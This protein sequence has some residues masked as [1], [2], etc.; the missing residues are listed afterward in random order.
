MDTDG[1]REHPEFPASL[2]QLRSVEMCPYCF[3]A[4]RGADAC[5]ECGLDLTD[6]R[7]ADVFTLS[8]RAATALSLRGQLL[9]GVIGA[10]RE[11][12]DTRIEAEAEAPAT[13]STA[14]AD[15]MPPLPEISAE[16]VHPVEPIS[17]TPP[18]PP[19][20][21][22]PRVSTPDTAPSAQPARP[23]IAGAWMTSAPDAAGGWGARAT[24][25]QAAAAEPAKP[26]R[27]GVQLALLV[28]GIAFL[29]VAAIVFLTVAFVLFDLMVKALITAAVT[30]TVI[31][32]A[33]W[34]GRRKMTATAEGVAVLGVVL[35]GLDF[36]AVR[37][38][39]MFGLDV[40]DPASYWG[41][42]L[43]GLT[44]I[45]LG[46]TRLSG[47]ATPKF[48]AAL[49]GLPAVLL[50]VASLTQL[51]PGGDALWGLS[52]AAAAAASAATPL[53][54]RTST[55]EGGRAPD[56]LPVGLNLGIGLLAGAIAPL[57]AGLG[58]TDTVDTT[59]A[60]VSMLLALGGSL[61]IVFWHDRARPG[62]PFGAFAHIAAAL[63]AWH[64]LALGHKVGQLATAAGSDAVDP[65]QGLP[66]ALPVLVAL[67]LVWQRLP[68][69]AP[70]RR[71]I[72]QV[73]TIAAAVAAVV[74]VVM[75]LWH[76]TVVGVD[77]A[78]NG[79]DV[80][81]RSALAIPAFLTAAL[82]A[83]PLVGMRFDSDVLPRRALTRI[84]AGV[85]GVL[86]TVGAAGLPRPAVY[87]T[88]CVAL[89]L[90]VALVVVAR[91]DAGADARG[92]TDAQATAD[93][94]VAADARAQA[95]QTL[96]ARGHAPFGV[97]G[98]ALT[99]ASATLLE[100]F[101]GI[102][103]ALATV[104]L[105]ALALA[106][107]ATRFIRVAAPGAWLSAAGISVAAIA[108]GNAFLSP[109]EW[110]PAAPLDSLARLF[111]LTLVPALLL[112]LGALG[113]ASR[114]S[115][116]EPPLLAGAGLA[117]ALPLGV[118]PMFA[119]VRDTDGYA[120]TYFA[121]AAL[122]LALIVAAAISAARHES[123]GRGP[124]I[125]LVGIVPVTVTA[126]W[127]LLHTI[128]G[129][130]AVW[131]AP[132]AAMTVAVLALIV[133]VATRARI[134]TLATEATNL[135]VVGAALLWLL[136]RSWTGPFEVADWLAFAVVLAAPLLSVVAA[137]RHPRWRAAAPW[138][139]A[140]ALAL[141]GP[142]FVVST[143]TGE[144][145]AIL[146]ATPVI[147]VAVTAFI[148]ALARSGRYSG[149]AAQLAISA[150]AALFV[151]NGALVTDWQR[152]PA[153]PTLLAINFVV[154]AVAWR[155]APPVGRWVRAAAGTVAAHGVLVGF[156]AVAAWLLDTWNAQGGLSGWTVSL[157][158]GAATL[159]GVTLALGAT[160]RILAHS[161][162]L[163][164]ALRRAIAI[165]ALAA[166][167]VTV[168]VMPVALAVTAARPLDVVAVVAAVPAAI[169]AV[170][171]WQRD[172]VGSLIGGVA[173]A[174]ASAVAI[175]V[176]GL[177][178]LGQL[179]AYRADVATQVVVTAI[180]AIGAAL[181]L[182]RAVSTQLRWPA[183]WLLLTA[184][185]L[186]FDPLGTWWAI[187]AASVP[188]LGVAVTTAV[189]HWRDETAKPRAELFVLALPLLTATMTSELDHGKLALLVTGLAA[190]IVAFGATLPRAFSVG[191]ALARA[192]STGL[193][194]IALLWLWGGGPS[195]EPYFIGAI[196]LVSVAGVWLVLR[197]FPQASVV[198]ERCVYAAGAPVLFTAIVTGVLAE[199]PVATA[200][201]VVV[202]ALVALGVSAVAERVRAGDVVAAS[203][204][205]LSFT[206]MGASIAFAE[207]V[208]AAD[209]WM[210][211]PVLLC[212]VAAGAIAMRGRPGLRSF[213]AVGAPLG[214]ALFVLVNSEGVTPSW[215]RIG[216]ATVLIVATILVGA[217]GRLQAPLV[218]GI[219]AAIA[220][221]FVAGRTV[222]PDIAIPWWAWLAAAGIVLVFVA[223][224]YERRMQQARRIAVGLR[225]M[226]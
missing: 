133:R 18:A 181:T 35:L 177:T 10:Q 17:S 81:G 51:R 78:A 53:L 42:A 194:I 213:A 158:L 24:P 161:A 83:L 45:L 62:G 75:F 192:G 41:T 136:L 190:M 32:T 52:F 142:G 67:A 3:T 134:D 28:T 188:A 59:I 46:W 70:S 27:S 122:T 216:L 217:L 113:A 49:T 105:T 139:P 92:G 164:E 130:A 137:N 106:L 150:V 80:A 47:L 189:R 96:P 21:P 65:G 11:A 168:A 61:A 207:G 180:A 221:V 173:L 201:G 206:A 69:R 68:L 169:A 114:L 211:L 125:A 63:V 143:V 14:A 205:T 223:A 175:G 135:L 89:A 123:P 79:D 40:A 209:V 71:S 29:A 44:A 34:L 36:W 115:K 222:L 184:L 38:L 97:A 153:A 159:V 199:T 6:A 218:L 76:I 9:Q 147:A 118:F 77:L 151:T 202:S 104:A 186:Y 98:T 214:L 31:A 185:P 138:I 219:I 196:G 155:A 132:I 82:A 15:E 178:L 4:T 116:H 112:G 56:P 30:A 203:L 99:I 73:G 119:L 95:A 48:V 102:G 172:A 117:L 25:S 8:E 72:V 215:W 140:A 1:R 33:S 12:E 191:R 127:A 176:A 121:L 26:K 58:R 124:A 2:R 7:L 19:A 200:I 160:L 16:P 66:Y 120:V 154:V 60:V 22:E 111:L 165:A 43:A 107:I 131:Q 144:P 152:Y 126:T 193:T 20:P 198:A 87:P 110:G 183:A 74:P 171:W 220:H 156:A 54:W 100:G 13:A 226:R 128:E 129:V 39:G 212:G 86:L 146:V 163:A 187:I 157:T 50:L 85:A 103:S 225:A 174:C 149:A 162:E 93:A 90:G 179:D 210:L 170:W 167:L 148:V 55:P 94:R 224:T 182:P 195:P 64:A 23:S 109:V 37:A 5:G 145:L 91:L 84:G 88:L 204:G 101:A 166:T 197:V 108:W 57:A 141:L 208:E